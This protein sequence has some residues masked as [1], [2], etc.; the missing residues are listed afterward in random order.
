MSETKLEAALDLMRRL[1]PA[2][3]QTNLSFLVAVAPDISE[4]ILANVDAP[5]QVY[6]CE[7]TQKPFVVCDFNRD[8]DSY[9]SPWSNEYQPRLDDGILPSERM[10]NLEVKANEIYAEYF[11]Q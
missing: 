7:Q 10:R 6:T 2:Q 1:P 11:R 3:L 4:D 5:L 9:R 8:Q